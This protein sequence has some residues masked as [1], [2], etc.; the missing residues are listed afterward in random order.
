MKMRLVIILVLSLALGLAGACGGGGGGGGNSLSKD[1]II[2]MLGNSITH[3]GGWAGLFPDNTILNYGKDGDLTSGMLS[4]LSSALSRGPKVICI[5]GGI[6]D[7]V[8]GISVATA[9]SNLRQIVVRSKAAGVIVIVQSTLHTGA[10]YPNSGAINVKVSQL[11][12]LLSA[13]ASEQSATWLNLNSSMAADGYL[14]VEFLLS[15]NLHL[16]G[17]GYAHWAEKLNSALP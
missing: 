15:D 11:N 10:G 7:I 5:M 3:R 8:R 4:R 14:K 9:Y 2:I 13:L 12:E 17:D 6:N 1:D 16:N